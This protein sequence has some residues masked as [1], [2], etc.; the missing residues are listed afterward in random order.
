MGGRLRRFSWRPVCFPLLQQKRNRT[1]RAWAGT[2]CAER[3]QSPYEVWDT[4]TKRRD[5][6]PPAAGPAPSWA[7]L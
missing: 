2:H 1:P 3:P 5:L 7:L 6:R 4:C